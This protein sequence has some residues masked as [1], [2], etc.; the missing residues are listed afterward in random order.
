M[1]V[2]LSICGRSRSTAVTAAGVIKRKFRA[3]ASLPP[4][5][6]EAER[7]ERQKGCRIGRLT[8]RKGIGRLRENEQTAA[9]MTR[10]LSTLEA[11]QDRG[12]GRA[13]V[14]KGLCVGTGADSEEGPVSNRE[15]RVHP[16][17]WASSPA[18]TTINLGSR[19]L[20]APR[21][22]VASVRPAPNEICMSV[23]VHVQTRSEEEAA[24]KLK[25]SDTGSLP[26]ASS[27]HRSAQFRWQKANSFRR[28]EK[29]ISREW[30]RV[31]I[32]LSRV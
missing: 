10:E 22:K 3:P 1:T 4:C 11:C 16:K 27:V 13:A 30:P 7:G 12:G 24:V 19:L 14:G 29:L 26:P 6:K 20:P 28:S 5:R 31:D 17:R 25:R 18:R 9:T 8:Q 15:S 21:Q 32:G 23:R 2:Q